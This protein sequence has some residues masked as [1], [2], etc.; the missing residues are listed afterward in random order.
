MKKTLRINELLDFYNVLLSDKQRIAMEMYYREDFSLEEIGENLG[1]SKQAV[2]ENIKRSENKL[3]DFEDKLHLLS[4]YKIR[5]KKHREQRVI[6][7]QLRDITDDP[8]ILAALER[9]EALIE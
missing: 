9:L 5:L 3:I 1:I 2:S 6:I 4:N 8:E 7:S